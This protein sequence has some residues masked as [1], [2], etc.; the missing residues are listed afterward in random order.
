M[1][2]I[3]PLVIAFF[4]TACANTALT[5]APSLN[6]DKTATLP[7]TGIPSLTSTPTEVVDPVAG[8]KPK[9][10]TGLD[11]DAVRWIKEANDKTL[12]YL[13]ELTSL[14]EAQQW[15]ERHTPQSIPLINP[16]LY[17]DYN[18]LIPSGFS[19]TMI[20]NVYSVDGLE[21]LQSIGQIVHPAEYDSIYEDKYLKGQSFQTYV[22][23]DFIMSMNDVEDWTKRSQE[24]IGQIR[25]FFK[26]F[27]SRKL[28][29]DIPA[30]AK[31]N[32]TVVTQYWKPKNGYD[33]IVIPWDQADPVKDPSFFGSNSQMFRQKFV[34]A[35]GKLVSVAALNPALQVTDKLIWRL[36]FEPLALA[37]QTQQLP[38]IDLIG[39]DKNEMSREIRAKKIPDGNLFEIKDNIDLFILVLTPSDYAKEIGITVNFITTIP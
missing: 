21:Q 36:V 22:A 27:N 2:K 7:P 14:P 9:D 35:N 38:T 24:T 6:L 33:V 29:L 15:G 20:F 18:N 26:Y 17:P 16:D 23:D 12:Y 30:V 34:I 25:L 8:P 39:I 4:L 37:M 3:F 1:K 13:P 5:A 19:K 10:A 32:T 11:K 31:D 28:P